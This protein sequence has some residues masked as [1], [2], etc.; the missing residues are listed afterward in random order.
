MAEVEILSVDERDR[1]TYY[2]YDGR[3]IGLLPSDEIR[4]SGV[5]EEYAAPLK[6]EKDRFFPPDESNRNRDV[7]IARD[8]GRIFSRHLL[9]SRG[10]LLYPF[11]Q[12]TPHLCSGIVIVELE[13]GYEG[14]TE[15]SAIKTIGRMLRGDKGIDEQYYLDDDDEEL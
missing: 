3:L 1:I 5:Y 15:D 7:Q 4:A 12:I 9:A 10:D 11:V 6:H 2:R 8:T 14:R 13:S